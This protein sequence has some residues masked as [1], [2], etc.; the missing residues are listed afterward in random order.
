MRTRRVGTAHLLPDGW[1]PECTITHRDPSAGTHG[2]AA[3]SAER[4]NYVP[5]KGLVH[6]FC[7]GS[8]IA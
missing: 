5:R 1:L 8:L 3:G 4:W 7:S 2:L 6:F